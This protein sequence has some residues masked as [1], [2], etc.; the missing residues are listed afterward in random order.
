MRQIVLNRVAEFGH[1]PVTAHWAGDV[2]HVFKV[3]SPA[4]VEDRQ[5]GQ[6][7]VC[8]A[9]NRS[10]LATEEVTRYR[11]EREERGYGFRDQHRRDSKAGP[12]AY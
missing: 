2:P 11:E 5:E 8:A 3:T 10:E 4:I 7:K 12:P 6:G 1:E 9:L